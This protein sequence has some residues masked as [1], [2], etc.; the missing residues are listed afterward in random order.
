[1][2]QLSMY[3]EA[4]ESYDLSRANQ[5]L[6]NAIGKMV[7]E[8][9][10]QACDR[11]M[12]KAILSDD[13]TDQAR[14]TQSFPRNGKVIDMSCRKRTN[15]NFK[16]NCKH[17]AKQQTVYPIRTFNEVLQMA[18]WLYDHKDRK[19]VLAFIVG[20]NVGLRANELL[21]LRMNQVFD[22]YGMVRCNLDPT[23]TSDVIYVY[24]GKT[25]K[26]RPIFL[27]RACKRA[28]EWYFPD[29]GSH[30]HSDDFLFP[31]R[32]GGSIQ[33]GT[34]RK[35]IKEAADAC[36]IRENIGTH[37][38][39]KTFAY[40]VWQQTPDVRTD[41]TVLQALLGHSSPQITMRYLGLDEV[42][43]KKVYY[44]L[45]LDVVDNSRFHGALD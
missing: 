1:M 2:S 41:I 25:D 22:E 45:K 27:N 15:P 44:K 34:F 6:T 3:P 28:L 31:S 13:E 33:V 35:V 42:E 11:E 17:G 23:V 14:K 24:Q 29:R 4:T 32:E 10:I 9:F 40:N 18:N 12:R 7:G 19:Y 8:Q 38:C 5:Q 26:N 43:F 37:T 39:R 21:S 36:G 30:L 16:Q 20:V